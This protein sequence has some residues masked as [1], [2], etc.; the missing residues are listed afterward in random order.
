MLC[1]KVLD[2]LSR[3]EST[4]GLSIRERNPMLVHLLASARNFYSDSLPR[5]LTNSSNSIT[6]SAYGIPDLDQCAS[7]MNSLPPSSAFSC[8]AACSSQSHTCLKRAMEALGLTVQVNDINGSITA[9]ALR[10]MTE[11]LALGPC[12]SV[13]VNDVMAISEYA[14]RG[15]GLSPCAHIEVAIYAALHTRFEATGHASDAAIPM[16]VTDVLSTALRSPGSEGLPAI[17]LAAAACSLLRHS[18]DENVGDVGRSQAERAMREV[19]EM[20]CTWR[21]GGCATVSALDETG[22]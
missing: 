12:C 20:F 6:P 22:F 2:V 19:V 3:F 18:V 13:S 7:S 5:T 16:A 11:L 8:N 21:R 14:K 17:I 15:M 10:A 1:S 4:I 9:D